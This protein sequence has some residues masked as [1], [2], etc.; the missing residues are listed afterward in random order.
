MAATW[1]RS[2]WIPASAWGR[3]EPAGAVALV[4]ATTSRTFGAS[5]IRPSKSVDRLGPGSGSIMSRSHEYVMT[6]GG[7]LRLRTE[8]SAAP[9]MASPPPPAATIRYPTFDRLPAI[10]LWGP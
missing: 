7:P 5:W 1:P 6:M 8:R 2:R 4:D 10:R 3:D 9:V